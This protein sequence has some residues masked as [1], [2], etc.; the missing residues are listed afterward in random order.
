MR[1]E[2]RYD[3]GYKTSFKPYLHHFVYF[4][5]LYYRVWQPTKKPNY[6]RFTIFTYR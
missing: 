1:E 2:D 4:P 6:I 3:T 5:M